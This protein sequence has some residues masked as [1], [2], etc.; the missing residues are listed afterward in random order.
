MLTIDS[1]GHVINSKVTL[2]ICPNIE[3]GSMT[4]VTSI[5]VHQT[6]ASTAQSTFN[7]Y[8]AAKPNG[9]HFLIDKDGK[10]YQT[11]SVYKRT[12]HVG[13]LKARCVVENRCTPTELKAL[14]RFDPKGENQREQAK[15]HPDRYPANSDSIGIEIVGKAFKKPNVKEAVFESVTAEQNISLKW[16]V[17]ELQVTLGLALNEVYRHPEVSYKN[18]TEAKTASW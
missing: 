18:A 1:S 5:V 14:Q 9:A 2:Y 10:I 11:A 7:S 16:L 8:A 3:R 17:S 12:N 4:V 6:D 15:N 13:T